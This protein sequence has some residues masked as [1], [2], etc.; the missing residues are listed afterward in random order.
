M[1]GRLLIARVSTLETAKP[2][3]S[4]GCFLA[5]EEKSRSKKKEATKFHEP[6]SRLLPFWGVHGECQQYYSWTAI[7]SRL[8]IVG[9]L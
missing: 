1:E 6:Q 8:R 4:K 7:Q 5:N 9:P 3:S 2:D